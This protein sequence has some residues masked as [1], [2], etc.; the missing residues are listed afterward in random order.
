MHYFLQKYT[1]HGTEDAKTSPRLSKSFRIRWILA[2]VVMIKNKRES[3]HTIL[4][5]QKAGRNSS[6]LQQ[7][8]VIETRPLVCIMSGA[9]KTE[10]FEADVDYV[11]E[12][13]E[14]D[15]EDDFVPGVEEEASR[16]SCGAASR[17]RCSAS[18][19]CGP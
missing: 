3:Y 15:D 9:P 1:L 19:R 5:I 11:N 8:T 18:G 13:D 2:L 16:S 4:Y 12:D 14:E 7:E 10:D 6:V 17:T